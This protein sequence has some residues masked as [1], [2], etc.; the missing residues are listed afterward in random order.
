[1]AD[2]L[3][4]MLAILQRRKTA[5]GTEAAQQLR[6]VVIM[7]RRR[8]TDTEYPVEQIGVG[9]IEQR[10]ESPELLAVQRPERV[11]CK[12]TENKVTLLRPAIPTAKQQPPAANLELIFG[13][14]V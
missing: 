3:A 2:V 6:H 12:R 8:V 13:R 4:S 11:L 10:L 5:L 14:I 1:M 7:F 9:A